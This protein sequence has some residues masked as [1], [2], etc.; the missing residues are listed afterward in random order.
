MAIVRKPVEKDLMHVTKYAVDYTW[1]KLNKD[2]T[3][4]AKRL[5]NKKDWAADHLFNENPNCRLLVAEEN[6]NVV[7]YGF[8]EASQ[9]NEDTI[10]KIEEVFVDE[11]YRREGIGSE[12]VQSL[13]KW[14]RDR[15]VDR[16]EIGHSSEDTMTQ[17]FINSIGFSPDGI[18]SPDGKIDKKN[19]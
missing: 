11:F 12:L 3:Q 13:L 1:T 7:G 4:S 19:R 10:G 17:G 14:L 18:F 8:G 9:D 5:K 16:I 6:G 2:D 15:Q